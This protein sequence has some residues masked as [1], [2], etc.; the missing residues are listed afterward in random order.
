MQLM[1]FFQPIHSQEKPGQHGS[2]SAGETR[3]FISFNINQLIHQLFFGNVSR[4]LAVWNKSPH[5]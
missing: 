2:V 1:C 3:L 4:F 5:A